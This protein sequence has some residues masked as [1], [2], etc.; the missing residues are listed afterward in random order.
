MR[1][2]HFSDIHVTAFPLAH[3]VSL[4]QAKRVLGT[5]NYFVGGRREHFRGVEHRIERLLEDADAVGA[6]HVLCTGDIT[7]MSLEGEFAR[8]A[9]LYGD[10]RLNQ[11]ERYTVIAGNHDRYTRE[12]VEDR[13]FER[14]FRA[15]ASPSSDYPCVKRLAPSVRLVLVDVSRPTSFAST[16]LMGDAQ[17]KRLLEVLTDPS[18]ADQFVVLGLHYAL[19]R[20]GGGPDSPSHRLLDYRALLDVVDRSDVHLDLVLHGHL[21]RSY[22]VRTARRVAVC[23]GSA[24]DLAVACG[25]NVYE[26][27]VDRK[28]F[29]IERRAWNAAVDAYVRV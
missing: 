13:R 21:H 3:P 19:L 8:C 28:R 6:E 9:D 17:G 10:A 5:I 4:L 24:T 29:A 27:D 7:S 11:P 20:A 25:Y 18:L 2:A 14:Y 15:L 16:G 26:I 23:A 12:S 22:S 1:L